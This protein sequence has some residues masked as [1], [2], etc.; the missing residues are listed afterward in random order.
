ML[1]VIS[2][3][4]KP[5]LII[6]CLSA[7]CGHANGQQLITAG[8]PA[9]LDIRAAGIHS[10]RITLKPVSFNAEFPATP[11]LS[12]K[13]YPAPV[14]SLR[15]LSKKIKKR[16][17]NLIVHLQPNPLTV[18]VTNEKGEVIQRLVFL[19]DG[20]LAFQTGNRP[21]LGMGEGGPKP[22]KGEDWH[23]K[24]IEFDRRGRFFEMQPRW[25]SGAYGTRN[26]VPLLIGTGG[27][28]LFVNAPWVKVD[29]RGKETGYFIPWKPTAKDSIPQNEKNQGLDNG[30]GLPPAI[31]F[32]AGVYDVFVFDAYFPAQLMKDISLISG[33]AVLP[34]KW[35]MG[36]MQ[37]HRTL[38]DEKQ[39]MGIVDT[40][41]SKHIPLDAVI[42]LGTGFVSRGWNT[43][44]PSFDANPEV[45]NRPIKDFIADVHQRNVKVVLHIVPY[46]RDKL[47]TLHGSIPAKA[48]EKNDSGHIYNYWQKHLPLMNAGVDGF[49]PDEGDWFNLF[50]RIAR[51]Q[52]YYQ[53]PL[54]TRPNVRPWSLHRNGF[55]GIAKWGGW[56]WSGD[57]ES[58]WKTLE[59]QIAVGINHSL[60]LSPFWGSDI[61]GF[62]STAETTGELYARWFQFAAFTPSFRS[63]GRTWY[64]RLPWG[65]GL[66]EI[67]PRESGAYPLLS[68]INHPEIEPIVKKYDELRYQLLTYNYTLAWQARQTGMPMMRALWLQ[69]P[70][71]SYA[72]SLGNQ[73][74]WGA[75][76]LIAPVYQKGTATRNV[77]LPEGKWYDWWTNRVIKGGKTIT[78]P[79]DLATMPIYVRE[80]AIIP[81]DPV[82][83][84]A[85]EI[86]NEP[87]T[88]K[89]YTGKNGSC[90]LY[91]D[92]GSSLDY[93]HGKYT[94][95]KITWNNKAKTLIIEPVNDGSTEQRTFNVEL[96]PGKTLKTV[97]YSGKRVKTIF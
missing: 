8:K 88:L 76:L 90:M 60:S 92:D 78:R 30:K 89:I 61:G 57:T 75:D 63:H 37:S 14:I 73:Y 69:Y 20:T 33:P 47:P 1:M 25:Q 80:G 49:W 66:K 67:G 79:V 58:S 41:R 83:Q 11:A 91:E 39:M 81:L 54:S 2:F 4:R 71:D 65:W 13:T 24:P 31:S 94:L 35:A 51:H 18:T 62:Y 87:E 84:Y 44:Q 70:K 82:R 21:V 46:D 15:S 17:G 72:A 3:L 7:T 36:Y 85:A 27:W 42:Y 77:Y 53:G 32:V 40:F 97:K 50:E 43:K 10:L 55:L 86:I 95:T 29:L 9:Q 34:P 6:L 26:P 48:G 74:L 16:V 38:T 19:D 23:N 56:V 45:F 5:V 22:L 12:D 93:L 52:L 59:G 28:A 64:T 96:L 68:E